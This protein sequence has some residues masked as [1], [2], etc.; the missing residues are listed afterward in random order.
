MCET[1]HGLGSSMDVD[2]ALLVA[3]E[4]LS[5]NDGALRYYGELRKKEGWTVSTVES[6]ARHYD[7]DLETPW[8]DLPETGRHALLY[9]SGGKPIEFVNRTVKRVYAAAEASP[10][11]DCL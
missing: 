11:R 4:T 3:D 7:F 1:C 8:Q 10:L 9:G 5:L 6:I 2:P